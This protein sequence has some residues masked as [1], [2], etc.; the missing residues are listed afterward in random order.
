MVIDDDDVGFGRALAH[1]RDEAVVVARALG[2]EAV[3]ACVAAMSFQNGRS[4][5]RS[6]ISARSPVSVSL[7][8]SSISARGS[9]S[10]RVNPSDCA[11]RALV[12][13]L[14]AVQAQIVAAPLH[15]GG[16]ERDAERR[17]GATGRSL[18]KICSWRFLVP[19]E[20]STRWRLRIAGTDRRASCPCRCRLRRAARRR[21][22]TRRR[23]GLRHLELAGPRLEAGQRARERAVRRERR[24]DRVVQR[25]RRSCQFS[26]Y[27]G[28]FR[29]SASTS[30]RTDAERA[31]RRPATPARAR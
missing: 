7:R 12:A 22:R 25:R 3:L 18:K 10:S 11:R 27:S 5:G 31:R 19:V 21:R 9:T 26:G 6:S 2:A 4:S 8:Q 28:N 1:A 20:T 24:G 30:V 17:R 23:R 15:V 16:G 29:H 13:A 14:E